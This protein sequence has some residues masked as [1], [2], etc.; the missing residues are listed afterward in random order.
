[1]WGVWNLDGGVKLEE[2][3]STG[4]GLWLRKG[5]LPAGHCASIIYGTYLQRLGS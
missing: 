1:M 5:L 3:G 4:G 2:G